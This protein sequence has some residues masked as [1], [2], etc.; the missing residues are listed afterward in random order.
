MSGCLDCRTPGTYRAGQGIWARSTV[1]VDLGAVVYI[2]AAW[3]APG[4][5]GYRAE[6]IYR[7]SARGPCKGGARHTVLN[8]A[9]FE[10]V[11]GV[12]AV[13]VDPV[14]GVALRFAGIDDPHG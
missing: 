2:A 1:F 13:V 8:P 7:C 12:A 3:R 14:R 4:R 9:E 10:G 5:A 11:E 6:T